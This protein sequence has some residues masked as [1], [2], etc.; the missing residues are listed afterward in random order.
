MKINAKKIFKAAILL[1]TFPT[2]AQSIDINLIQSAFEAV[3]KDGFTIKRVNVTG[4]GEF[5]VVLKWDHATMSFF[6]QSATQSDT[7]QIKITGPTIVNENETA[8]F[9]ASVASSDGTSSTLNSPTWTVLPVGS[10]SINQS[11][12]FT[13]K[14]QTSDVDAII[15]V[16]GLV[17]GKIKSTSFTVKV[18]NVPSPK[19]TCTALL[20]NSYG[21]VLQGD[22]TIDPDTRRIDLKLTSLGGDPYFFYSRLFFVQGT[23]SIDTSMSTAD[24]DTATLIPSGGWSGYGQILAPAIKQVLITNIP[25]SINMSQTFQ[26]RYTTTFAPTD[27]SC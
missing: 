27:I 15:S 10:G 24:P 17:N 13:A 5:D 2:L 25:A 1:A 4:I 11:G 6:P 23:N 3:T 16:T 18:K 26:I 20:E 22:F 9:S 21:D 12:V 7:Y 19:R 8:T 14:A